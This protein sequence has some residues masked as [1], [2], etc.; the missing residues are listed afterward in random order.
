MAVISFVWQY[1]IS[2]YMASVSAFFSGFTQAETDSYFEYMSAVNSNKNF[3]TPYYKNLS[4]WFDEI[5]LT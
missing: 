1:Y 3:S 5:Q 2:L 4:R